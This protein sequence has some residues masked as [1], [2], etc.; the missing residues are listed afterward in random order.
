M[1]KSLYETLEVSSNATSEEIKKA[2]RRLARK[3]HPDINK[4]KDAEEKFKEINAAYEILSDEKKRKQYDQFGDSMFGGQNFHDFARG[5][6]NVDLD[7]ILSQIFGGGGF[8]QGTGNFGGFSG[9]SNFGGFGGFNQKS[10]PNLDI[11]AQ[12]TIPFST[13]ILGGKHNVSL[14]NQNFDIKIPAGIKNGETIR[15][16]GK[17]NTMGN[18]S[19]DVLL[20][21][22]VA[23]HPQYTQE[24][25][26]LTKKFDLPLK[27]AL[28][29]GK[30]EIE[31]LY[32]PIT[33]KVPKN[34]KN[35]QRFRVKEL[36]AYN[37]KSK[38]Y[39]DLYLEANIILP[40][41]DSLPKELVESLEKYL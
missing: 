40:D 13:A 12:I 20:K 38:I 2:Y 30:V 41:I 15:L 23:P 22:S 31:T 24:G 33:L 39:G 16:R 34:T 4:E 19:G 28:F 36:G 14:Q 18:Q 7:D 37:R 1:S 6:G 8:S 17:G 25:D 3:Y 29:G 10:Q 27:T 5:Q 32:K 26:N 21:V 11:N 35:N 9:F